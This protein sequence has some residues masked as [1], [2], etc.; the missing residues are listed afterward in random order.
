[1]AGHSQGS[2]NV[3]MVL[4]EYMKVHPEYLK[5]LV[6]AY[7]IGYSVD[8]EWLTKN[9]HIKFAEGETDTGCIVSYVVEGP[10]STMPTT[11]ASSDSLSI[12]PLNWKTDDTPAPAS[13]NKGR[14]VQNHLLHS[15]SIT[16]ENVS[17][18]VID[19]ERRTVICT[20]NTDY[21]KTSPIGDKSLHTYDYAE[22]YANL[23]E[24]GLKRCSAFLGHEAK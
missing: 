23:R 9:P 6:A 13:A 12:N 3:V 5:N 1:M 24:N 18:A 11:L 21:E 10:D 2:G 22:Y 17:G 4:E 20:T 15:W 14:L 16:K 8:D 7:V 19:P